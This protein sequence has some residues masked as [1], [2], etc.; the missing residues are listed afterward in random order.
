MRNGVFV[1]EDAKGMP[2]RSPLYQW[3]KKH[4]AAQYGFEITEV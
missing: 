4:F 3:K 1:V 2:G